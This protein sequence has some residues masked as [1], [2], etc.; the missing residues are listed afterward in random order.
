VDSL[1]TFFLFILFHVQLTNALFFRCLNWPQNLW[2]YLSK[3]LKKMSR[4]LKKASPSQKKSLAFSKK[5][6][7]KSKSAP[8]CWRR[9]LWISGQN[10]K[11]MRIDDAVCKDFRVTSGVPQ[12][13][14]LGSLFFIWFVNRIS[15]IYDYVCCVLLYDDDMKLFVPVKSFQDGLKI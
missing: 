9:C 4:I 1:K 10:S 6:L 13:S 15:N 14:H 5:V 3:S 8:V 7:R 11:R 2:R 12:G